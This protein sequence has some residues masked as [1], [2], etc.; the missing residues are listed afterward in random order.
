MCIY[1][2]TIPGAPTDL[3][4]VKLVTKYDKDMIM[5]DESSISGTD[6]PPDASYAI[7]EIYSLRVSV[8]V[9]VCVPGGCC[10]I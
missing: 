1:C 5:T 6:S 7:T 9:G 4:G 2:R 10:S 8:W 3:G